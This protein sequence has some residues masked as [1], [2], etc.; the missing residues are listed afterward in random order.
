MLISSIEQAMMAD[1]NQSILI[2]MRQERAKAKVIKQ[3]KQRQLNQ[4]EN[5]DIQDTESKDAFTQRK[6]ILWVILA[7][8][9]AITVVGSQFLPGVGMHESLT[10]VYSS[11]LWCGI[12][13]AALWR[14]RLKNGWIGFAIGSVIGVTLNILA[15][16][17]SAG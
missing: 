12:L 14:Y 4:V 3:N 1:I 9:M 17:L 13:G 10:S 8:G 2:T 5:A 16:V 7:A 15:S 11:M 6:N